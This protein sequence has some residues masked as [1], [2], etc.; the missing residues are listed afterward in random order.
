MILMVYHSH[1]ALKSKWW[2]FFFFCHLN[3]CQGSMSRD[4]WMAS[5][6]GRSIKMRARSKMSTVPSGT[7][8]PISNCSSGPSLSFFLGFCK[9]PPYL[10]SNPD[11]I[12]WLAKGIMLFPTCASVEAAGGPRRLQ[13]PH[14]TLR[15]TQNTIAPEKPQ[16]CWRATQQFSPLE[17]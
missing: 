14:F 8:R 9:K 3:R 13:G 15:A 11:G 16:L 5:K 12:L 6:G 10:L 1:A 4:H 2:I 7:P 17:T